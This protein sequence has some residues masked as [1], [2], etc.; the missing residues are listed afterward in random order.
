MELKSKFE[1][2]LVRKYS[3]ENG[4][5]FIGWGAPVK[6]QSKGFSRRLG[7]KKFRLVDLV[8]ALK[9]QRGEL[10]IFD[11]TDNRPRKP[12][13]VELGFPV[14]LRSVFWVKCENGHFRQRRG[15]RIIDGC[16]CFDCYP[17]TKGQFKRCIEDLQL[18]AQ[19][20]GGECLSVEFKGVQ[21][22]YTWKCG[23]GHI[24]ESWG[25]DVLNRG[26]WCGFCSA[27]E[28]GEARRTNS[29]IRK[30]G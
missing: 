6:R 23:H 5:K 29:K 10:F 1:P 11:E 20:K 30:R 7:Q 28:K 13:T 15:D 16:R 2:G 14:A 17:G 27:I 4:K 3:Y 24:F 18:A 26:T 25:N 22:K 21:Q 8:R 12:I 9:G 19:K